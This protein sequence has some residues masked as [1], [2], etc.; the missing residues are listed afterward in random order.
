M[1]L[2]KSFALW[3]FLPSFFLLTKII[4]FFDL[5]SYYDV[6]MLQV[7]SYTRSVQRTGMNNTLSHNTNDISFIQLP[8]IHSYIYLFHV[9]QLQ[10]SPCS[11]V[12]I[13]RFICFSRVTSFYLIW[14]LS[15]AEFQL[16]EVNGF[17]IICMLGMKLTQMHFFL[18]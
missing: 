15:C 18:F 14:L 3:V 4:F 11:V 8:F 5:L 7:L 2:Q 9:D 16:N 6:I 10:A 13:D 1:K 17:Q 12:H